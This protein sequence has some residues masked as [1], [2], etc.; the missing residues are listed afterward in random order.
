MA[1]FVLRSR[2]TTAYPGAVSNSG[3]VDVE[4]ERRQ[5]LSAPER[6]QLI[7]GLDTATRRGPRCYSVAEHESGDG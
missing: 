1:E 4:C 5:S 6:A 2:F 7:N 3:F